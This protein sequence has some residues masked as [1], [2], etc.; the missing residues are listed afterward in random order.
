MLEVQ[1][2]VRP[3]P[4]SVKSTVAAMRQATRAVHSKQQAVVADAQAGPQRTRGE[5]APPSEQERRQHINDRNPTKL[6]KKLQEQLSNELMGRGEN[7]RPIIF[8]EE[9][10]PVLLERF[11]YTNKTYIKRRRLEE[12]EL[13]SF[14]IDKHTELIQTIQLELKA[15]EATLS[16]LAKESKT[17]KKPWSD[18]KA[19]ILFRGD[20][21]EMEDC[22]IS[23]ARSNVGCVQVWAAFEMR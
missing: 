4:G 3:V 2:A 19:S 18:A 20:D 8:E 7:N 12:L 14:D 15:E 10:K 16:P 1:Q 5:G 11:K 13:V 21:A 22:W 23:L 9:V 17:C 6:V